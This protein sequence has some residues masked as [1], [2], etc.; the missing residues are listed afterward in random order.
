MCWCCLSATEAYWGWKLTELWE[1]FTQAVFNTFSPPRYPHTLHH[2][3]TP[4]EVSTHCTHHHTWCPY[5]GGRSRREHFSEHLL[6]FS[7]FFFPVNTFVLQTLPVVSSQMVNTTSLLR[8]TKKTEIFLFLFVVSVKFLS[9]RVV[10]A[11]RSVYSVMNEKNPG[12]IRDRKHH[13]K[14]HRSPNRSCG[15]EMWPVVCE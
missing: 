6:R 10:K 4:T 1:S 11:A 5:W 13:L 7:T 14:T 9:D 8:G 15:A 3:P 2:F 12:L